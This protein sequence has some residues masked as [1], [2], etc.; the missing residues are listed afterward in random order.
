MSEWISVCDRLPKPSKDDDGYSITVLITDGRDISVGYHEYEYH[1]KDAK[2]ELQYS[3]EVWHDEAHRL[4]SEFGG[5]PNVTYWK[6][7]PELPKET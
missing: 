1:A 2:E 5:W 3:S 4:T 6:A 7:L